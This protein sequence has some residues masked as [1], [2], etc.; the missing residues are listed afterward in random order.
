MA[1][2][3]LGVACLLAIVVFAVN[4]FDLAHEV[5]IYGIALG[6]PCLS[7]SAYVTHALGGI[8]IIPES[9]IAV[10]TITMAVGMKTMVLRKVIVRKLDALEALGGIDSICSDKTGRLLFLPRT[11][12]QVTQEPSHRAR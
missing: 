12:A 7:F 6:E 3:L 5:V 10:L 4:N 8:A 11:A 2:A 9:L 1:F